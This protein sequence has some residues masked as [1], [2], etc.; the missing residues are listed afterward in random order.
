MQTKQGDDAVGLTSEEFEDHLAKI[1]DIARARLHER[2]P[3]TDGGVTVMLDNAKWHKESQKN[4]PGMCP[5]L[6]PYSPE[7]N[8]PVEHA[9]NTIKREFGQRLSADRSVTTL[10]AAAA[11]FERV[12]HEVITAESVAK[13]A[14]TMKATM[15]AMVKAKGGYLP[16]HLS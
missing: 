8:K 6:P 9:W 2:K 3:F 5:K 10:A 13:D 7:T 11:L 4:R 15:V 12:A 1:I 14:A 16:K